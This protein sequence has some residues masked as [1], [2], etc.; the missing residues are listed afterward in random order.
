MG[1]LIEFEILYSVGR[2]DAT[3]FYRPDNT[4]NNTILKD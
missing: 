2:E 1:I 4:Q 3:V